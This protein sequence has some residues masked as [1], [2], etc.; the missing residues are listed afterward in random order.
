V[1]LTGIIGRNA[2]FLNENRDAPVLEHAQSLIQSPTRFLSALQ[3]I[4]S[5]MEWEG[6]VEVWS[7]RLVV[8]GLG[9][10]GLCRVCSLW[11]VV[12]G[13]VAWGLG[14][15]G[16][17]IGGKFDAFFCQKQLHSLFAP[18]LRER[19]S[20]EELQVFPRRTSLKGRLKTSI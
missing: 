9:I 7:G 15:G 3:T 5:L 8:R 20:L 4:E 19:S 6:C 18:D 11:F 12:C 1:H 2:D 10:R 14:I 16:G 17:V 13:G